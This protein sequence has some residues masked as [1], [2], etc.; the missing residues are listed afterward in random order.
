MDDDT[1]LSRITK[2]S[3]EEPLEVSHSELK[4]KT[5]SPSR[6]TIQSSEI[7]QLELPPIMGAPHLI[8]PNDPDCLFFV[9]TS[10][11]SAGRPTEQTIHSY[12][13]AEKTSQNDMWDR[14]QE[15]YR[16]IAEYVRVLL[17][18][19]YYRDLL[20][21]TSQGEA[22]TKIGGI[23]N[24]QTPHISSV[25]NQMAAIENVSQEEKTQQ[26]T[27]SFSEIIL[28]L[29]GSLLSG[30]LVI[31]VASGPAGSLVQVI[32]SLQPLFP[33]VAVQNLIPLINLTIMGPIYFNLWNESRE[34]QAQ[35]TPR[36]RTHIRTIQTFSKNILKIVNDPSFISSTLLAQIKGSESLSREDLCR[37]S[38]MLKIILLGTALSLMYSADVGKVQDGKFGGMTSE[39]FKSLLLGEWNDLSESHIPKNEHEEI[40]NSLIKQMWLILHELKNDDRAYILERLFNYVADPKMLSPMLEPSKVFKEVLA[41]QTFQ[42]TDK[43]N[44]LP[45]LR[46]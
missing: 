36:E 15:T 10:V 34:K 9:V 19:P 45:N 38:N 16:E 8:P 25:I 46:G 29:T 23:Q 30:A 43:Y 14:F 37:L 31:G 44:D 39:E 27:S 22:T 5:S 4:K 26:K 21:I 35:E 24:I 7:I 40:T 6:D 11:D 18:N 3:F 42:I 13:N 1:N 20:Q 12:V 17:A 41:S 2:I 33:Q 32:E 28:P